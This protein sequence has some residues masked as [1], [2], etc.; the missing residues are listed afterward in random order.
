MRRAHRPTGEL[1][2]VPRA[3]IGERRTITK[4]RNPRTA[5]TNPTAGEVAT[6][7][8][9]PIMAQTELAEEKRTTLG[10]GEEP[11]AETAVV[12]EAEVAQ[13]AEGAETM[14]RMAEAE[15]AAA[16][17]ETRRP[18]GREAEML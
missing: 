2:M 14:A 10:K 18:T 9:R 1:H 4:R 13:Q 3:I 17:I 6:T 16:A 15:D 8:T 7:S 11:V 5:E 12:E